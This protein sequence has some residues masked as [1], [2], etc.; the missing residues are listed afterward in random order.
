ML[1][2]VPVTETFFVMLRAWLETIADRD[3]CVFDEQVL[4]ENEM[5]LSIVVSHLLG[6][7]RSF[8]FR[9][10]LTTDVDR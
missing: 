4:V 10:W 6:D 8:D 9:S 1:L 5:L 3:R 7:E 2:A